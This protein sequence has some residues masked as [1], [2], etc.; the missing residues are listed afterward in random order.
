MVLVIGHWS[1]V[2][3]HWSFVIGSGSILLP[4]I[5]YENAADYI[6]SESKIIDLM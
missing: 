1:L 3:G 4:E 2:I 6:E 5:L